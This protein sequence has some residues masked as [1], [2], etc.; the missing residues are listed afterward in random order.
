MSFVGSKSHQQ[1]PNEFFSDYTKNYLKILGK[2]EVL[3]SEQQQELLK[4]Y[5]NG[6][7]NAYDK[8]IL[9]NM[10][11]CILLANEYRGK[12]F[13][14]QEILSWAVLGLI[15]AIRTYNIDK[16]N[17]S[18]FG[19]WASY[20]IKQ[21]IKTNLCQDRIIRIPV[22]SKQKMYKIA[23]LLE[24]NPSIS[25]VQISEKIGSSVRSVRK[26]RLNNFRMVFL[27]Q[28]NKNE[29][30]N[31][32][33]LD[34]IGSNNNEDN[35]EYVQWLIEDLDERSLQIISMRYGLGEYESHTLQEIA[36]K[37]GLT[38]ERIRQLQVNA[39]NTLKQKMNKLY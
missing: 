4:A 23:K 7:Q 38:R 2:E 13:E 30:D 8:L 10:R 35:T 18:C 39:L 20:W 33:G 29:D 1:L 5:K 21:K 32:S 34:F 19:T 12:G 15:K 27:D 36:D 9:T 22:S 25:D 6:D 24:E 26:M 28:K 14:L 11:L 17:G 16:S 3:T 31:R 37:I